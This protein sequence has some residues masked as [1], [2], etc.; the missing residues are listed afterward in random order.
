MKYNGTKVCTNRPSLLLRNKISRNIVGVL[1]S[2]PGI[3]W[4]IAYL[5]YSAY[6]G[7]MAHWSLS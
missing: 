6:A 3:K 5:M 2:V 4:D 1:E 7:E